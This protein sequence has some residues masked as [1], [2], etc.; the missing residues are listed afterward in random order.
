MATFRCGEQNISKVNQRSTPTTWP[1]VCQIGQMK[2]VLL[3]L[4]LKNRAMTFVNLRLGHLE[5]SIHVKHSID[6]SSRECYF[7]IKNVSFY[8]LFSRPYTIMRLQHIKMQNAFTRII[9]RDE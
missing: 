6:G 3:N 8:S 1:F 4:V 7:R 9:F 5:L 2:L